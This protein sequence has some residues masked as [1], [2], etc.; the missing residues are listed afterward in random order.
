MFHNFKVCFSKVRLR[1][2]KLKIF[3]SIDFC[4]PSTSSI[5][6]FLFILLVLY[7]DYKHKKALSPALDSKHLVLNCLKRKN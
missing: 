2:S 6:F 4:N 1:F 3:S 7:N 5:L